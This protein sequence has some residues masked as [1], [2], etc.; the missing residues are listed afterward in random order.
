MA[1][2][3]DQEIERRRRKFAQ[4][5]TPSRAMPTAW[6]RRHPRERE[7]RRAEVLP[8]LVGLEESGDEQFKA[9]TGQCGRRSAKRWSR[10]RLVGQPAIDACQLASAHTQCRP[11]G[12]GRSRG[13]HG[14]LG[15]ESSPHKPMVRA[16]RQMFALGGLR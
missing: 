2:H 13:G 11:S 10:P 8:I 7:A 12:S 9:K 5:S 6:A 1:E 16:G 15:R 3:T 14:C 4:V